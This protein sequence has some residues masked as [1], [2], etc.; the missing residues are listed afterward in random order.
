MNF[1]VYRIPRQSFVYLILLRDTGIYLARIYQKLSLP[2]VYGHFPIQ[3]GMRVN[4]SFCPFFNFPRI[5]ERHLCEHR[6]LKQ[7]V[8]SF[9][10]GYLE[11]SEYQNLVVYQF[12][13]PLLFVFEDLQAAENVHSR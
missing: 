3:F 1:I 2:S 12:F 4:I 11:Y 13:V 7:T 5:W 8:R 9:P 6:T 10:L